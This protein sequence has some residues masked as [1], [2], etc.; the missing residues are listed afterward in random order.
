MLYGG[1]V[2]AQ[3]RNVVRELLRSGQTINR[4]YVQNNLSDKVSNEIIALAKQNGVKID[5]VSKMVLDKKAQHHQGFVCETTDFEYS[6][7]EDILNSAE[8]GKRFIVILDGIEDPHNLGAI[9]RTCEC[10]GV[11]GIIIQDRRA[12]QVNDTVIK[13]SAGATTNMKIARV[14]NLNNVICDLKKQNIWVYALELGG[15]DIYKTNLTGDIA[16]VIGSEGFGVSRLLKQNCDDVI[17]LKQLGKINSLN[18]SVAAG[19]AIYEVLRQR[20]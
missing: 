3:G 19:I 14:T 6:T 10:A 13:T 5:F 12:C 4:L 18:A 15:K 17:T 20:C 16:L 2:I 11:N 1:Y 7:V 8:V 9:I